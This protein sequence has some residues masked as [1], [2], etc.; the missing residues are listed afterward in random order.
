M[1]FGLQ[2]A[3]SNGFKD[4]YKACKTCLVDKSMVVRWAAAKV[5]GVDLFFVIEFL[6][7]RGHQHTCL[8]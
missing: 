3:A 5:S 8:C 1:L 2:N 7:M 4:I 6:S